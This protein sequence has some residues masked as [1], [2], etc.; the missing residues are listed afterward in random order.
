MYVNTVVECKMNID[1]SYQSIFLFLN[2]SR[3]RLVDILELTSVRVDINVACSAVSL[4]S[5]AVGAYCLFSPCIVFTQPSTDSMQSKDTSFNNEKYNTIANPI[6]T[7]P[8]DSKYNEQK[9]AWPVGG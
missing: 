8:F 2:N 4:S 5:I 3:F 7:V 9:R 6:I 1:I